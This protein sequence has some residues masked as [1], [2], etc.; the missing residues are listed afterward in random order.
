V[1]LV[2]LVQIMLSVIGRCQE[3]LLQDQAET[4]LVIRGT[5]THLLGPEQPCAEGGKAWPA[6][7]CELE[8]LLARALESTE[9][10]QPQRALAGGALGAAA[11]TGA[12]V[13]ALPYHQELAACFHRLSVALQESHPRAVEM[14]RLRFSGLG[15]REIAERLHLPFRLVEQVFSAIR[16]RIFAFSHEA[17]VP[18]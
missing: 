2:P 4:L 11:N 5:L 7:A 10:A 1:E 12:N 17:G 8:R 18:E 15:S 9:R 14:L 6:I 16:Q 13:L 3:A